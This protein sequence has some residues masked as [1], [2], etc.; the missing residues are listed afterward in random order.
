MKYDT[1]LVC[2]RNFLLVSTMALI[3]T[4][5]ESALA[6]FSITIDPDAYTGKYSVPGAVSV[7]GVQIVSLNAG[8]HF[9]DIGPGINFSFSVSSTGD[10]TSG[11]PA[12]AHGVG[13]TLT[14]HT[15]TISVDPTVDYT[16]TYSLRGV[17]ISSSS[18]LE[19]F[20][21]LPGIGGYL[22][23]IAPGVGFRFEV[24]SSGQVTSRNLTAAHGVGST[25]VFDTTT[26]SVDPTVDYTGTY[27]LRGVDRSSSSGL[28]SFVLL[29]GI[30]GYLLDIAPGVG[31]RFDVSSSGQ[32]TS[33]NLT[34]AH[35][36]GSTL[37]F[38]TTTIFV[39]PIDY[40]GNYGIRGVASFGSSG[41]ESFNLLPGISGYILDIAPGINTRFN[42][43]S[44]CA[45]PPEVFV[46]GFTFEL[47]CGA[48]DSDGDGVPDDNDNCPA[49]PNPEQ[50]DQ[51]L[52]GTGNVCDSDLDGDSFNN[53]SDNCP[54][55][56]NPDQ[57]DLDGDGTGDDCDTDTDGDSVSDDDDNCPFVANSG[58][59]DSDGDTDGDACDTDD[60]NDTVIDEMD[61]CPVIF[62]PDQF[63]FDGDE[64]GDA[65]DGDT[66][67]DGVVNENDVCPGSPLI[68]PVDFD[69]CT[70]P[71]H[72]ALL[73]DPENFVQ[74]GQYVSCVAHAAGDAADAGLISNKQKARFVKEAARSN[75]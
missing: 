15:T 10:V 51:D 71:Q 68:Q 13:S 18:G 26:I 14:F 1:K 36:V 8:T 35:G 53:D 12:A 64:E 73:C 22:L 52:D 19:S 43:A 74:H 50:I 38:D 69:G 62:N 9:V 34:A 70:G 72:I 57:L 29:P 63:D 44:P 58:Q 16:G 48:P 41:L 32:V 59:A 5:S 7:T 75:Q 67:G 37:V 2:A 55:L 65:C 25:L 24:S 45:V 61:N 11:N 3:V 49:I 42:V 17:D 21:L 27:S 4:F 39:D 40:T 20:V 54:E 33:R 30:G 56:A 31:F 28:E 66:D 46:D 60:D 23:D 47:S 6:A